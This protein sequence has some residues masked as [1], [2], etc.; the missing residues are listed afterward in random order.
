MRDKILVIEDNP[1]SRK[2]LRVALEAYD[3]AVIEAPDGKTALALMAEEMPDLVLQDLVLPDINGFELVLQLRALPGREK[4]P[5]LAMTGLIAKVDEL[6][7]ADAP[8]NDYL[9]KPIQPSNLVETV[10]SYLP[11][12]KYSAGQPGRNRR[13]L[14]VD[15]EPSQRKLLVTYLEQLG[16]DVS[17]AADGNDAL[18]Q[19]R[20]YRPN[21]I[22]SDVLMPNLD[23]FQLCL[24]VRADPELAAIPVVLR[25]NNYDQEADKELARKVGA[26]ALVATDPDFREAIRALFDS[27]DSTPALLLHDPQAFQAAHEERLAYQLHRQATLSAQLARRCA[28]QNAQ[29][30]VLASMA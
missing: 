9:F 2:M 20:A 3:Y 19:A 10:R 18:I 7:L 24:K 22:L 12:G 30:S 8:F 17:S 15:D 1:I 11:F 16:F 13:V 4:I 23:G 6:R 26:Y 25:S 21:A 27:L 14:V 5:I 29:V 28:A